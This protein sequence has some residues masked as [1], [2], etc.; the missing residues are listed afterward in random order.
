MDT[1]LNRY[2][3]FQAPSGIGCFLGVPLVLAD[4]TIYGTLCAVDPEPQDLTAEHV[5][6]L[7][8]LARLLATHIEHGRT[9]ESHARMVRDM[10]VLL[11]SERAAR[12]ALEAATIR[13]QLLADI[14]D[15]AMQSLDYPTTLAQITTGLVP[16]MADWSIV[17]ILEDEDQPPTVHIAAAADADTTINMLLQRFPPE[18]QSEQSI[19]GQV[20]HR[21]RTVY[22]PTIDDACLADLAINTD[23]LALLCKLKMQ[24]LLVVPL[25]THNK[26]LG[27]LLLAMGASCRTFTPDDRWM[28]EE[29]A[30][31]AAQAIAHAR[32]Y[33]AEQQA[34]REKTSALA[35]VDTLVATAPIGVAFLD[36]DLRYQ[37]INNHLAAINGLPVSAHLGRTMPQIIPHLAGGIEPL[38]REVLTTGQPIVDLQITGETPDDPGERRFWR[39]SYYPVPDGAGSFQ[40]VGTVVLDITEQ[41]RMTAAIRDSEERFRLVVASVKDYAIFMLDP[42]GLI[43]SWNAGAE[44]IHGYQ[45]DEI[46]GRHFGCFYPADDRAGSLPERA[47]AIATANGSYE[48]EGWRVRQNGSRFWANVVITPIYSVDGVLKGFAKVT[49]DMTERRL[50]D[51]RLRMSEARLAGVI[52]SA[53]DAIIT[54]DASQH[55]LV[56]NAAAE[57]LL[58]CTAAQAIGQPLSQF[59]PERYRAA[60]AQHLPAF[61]HTG[62]TNR[63][64][65]T[66]QPL[67]ALRCDGSEVPIEATISQVE[68]GGEKL[69]TVIMRDVTERV[70]AEQEREHLLAQEQEARIAAESAVQARET[71]L[72]VAA[73]ELK[74]PLTTLLGHTFLLQ[75]TRQVVGLTPIQL[76]SV[77]AINQQAQRLNTLVD[78]VL[79]VAR[80]QHGHLQ[81]DMQPL[82]MTGLVRRIADEWRPMM[83]RHTLEVRLPSYDIIVQGDETRLTQ[84]LNNLLNNAVKYSPQGG[85]VHLMLEHNNDSVCIAVRDHGIGIPQAA[86]AQL[87]LPF[88]RAG[89]VD[90]KKI[91]G[92]G[93]G[94]HMV[95]DIVKLHSGTIHVDSTEGQGSLFTFCLPC[96]EDNMNKQEP[97]W[98]TSEWKGAKFDC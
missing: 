5:D 76:G 31:P 77:Q 11:E 70:R 51:D 17:Y 67:T 30:V 84:V 7:L 66:L 3:T 78:T 91:S 48:K 69:Y 36:C 83:E 42:A 26:V 60:H 46:V 95:H 82:E 61:G 35:L 93:L 40:G 88:F 10:A 64:M 80:S 45:A 12:A 44:S 4:G 85:P 39:A 29:I 90:P 75:R 58:R 2:P 56:F 55:I 81:I 68:A 38:M 25:R 41:L 20:L 43:L 92:F 37:L 34:V 71:F 86:Q 23:H 6:L 98:D 16:G 87:F 47:L 15:R 13:A 22:I 74:T 73:H 94:L 32:L 21:G 79:D 1:I 96:R 9:L 53:M 8:V 49:R 50:A 24:A 54:V 28:A 62:V 65:R 19:I 27:F 18:Q 97:L 52:E 14:R 33:R 59:I 57:Q 63:S 89:N 72:S